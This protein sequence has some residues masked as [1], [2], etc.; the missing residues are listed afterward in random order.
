MSTAT[1]SAPKSARTRYIRQLQAAILRHVLY[2][3]DVHAD[4]AI[5]SLPVPEGVHVNTVGAAF[6]GL[7]GAGLIEAVGFERSVRASRH[8][9]V[10][11][12]WRVCDASG[13][14]GYLTALERT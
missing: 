3:G 5:A 9:G 13:A 12:I 4:M 6:S 2:R 14:R 8:R 1:V 10:S 11:R 7:E